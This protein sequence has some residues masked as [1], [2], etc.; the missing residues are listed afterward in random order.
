MMVYGGEVVY[1]RWKVVYGVWRFMAV[2]GGE[3]VYEV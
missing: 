2:Y 3:V 1:E